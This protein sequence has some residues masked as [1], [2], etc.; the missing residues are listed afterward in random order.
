M[1]FLR[2]RCEPR[3]GCKHLGYCEGAE[4]AVDGLRCCAV[5]VEL[6]EGAPKNQLRP[7]KSRFPFVQSSTSVG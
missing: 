4:F 3:N 5:S 6:I 1:G 2:F 7:K